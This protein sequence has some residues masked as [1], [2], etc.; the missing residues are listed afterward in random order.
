MSVKTENI[1]FSIINHTKG[2]LTSL[3]FVQYKNAILGENY[4]LVVNFVSDT[5]IKKLNKIYRN[6]D[7]PTDI[8]SFPLTK[9][10][11][12][13]FIS[14]KYANKKAPTF[15]RDNTNYLAFLVIHGLVHLKGFEHCSKMEEIEAEYQKIFGI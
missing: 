7:K 1:N 15:N 3:P 12:E 9:D 10:T 8:L 6:I 13:I 5:E 4:N 14:L 11:G 2:K